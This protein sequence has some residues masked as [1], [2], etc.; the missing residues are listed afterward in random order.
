MR[1]RE[2]WQLRLQSAAITIAVVAAGGVVQFYLAQ[3]GERERLRRLT[4]EVCC[5][6]C[7]CYCCCC[8][9]CCFPSLL[10]RL[11]R[12]LCIL[13]CVHTRAAAACSWLK[14]LR[15]VPECEYMQSI[16]VVMPLGLLTLCLLLA[17]TPHWL[18][19]AQAVGNLTRT[20]ETQQCRPGSSRVA[21]R[22]IVRADNATW[23]SA[24]PHRDSTS[25]LRALTNCPLVAPVMPMPCLGYA[26]QQLVSR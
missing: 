15:A 17:P 26:L 9:C 10:L 2:A 13:T 6:C 3:A 1:G 16:H 18:G 19:T 20:C 8:C 4:Y 12:H 22:V 23:N 25:A 14:I 21:V 11:C 5:C 7:C 24:D